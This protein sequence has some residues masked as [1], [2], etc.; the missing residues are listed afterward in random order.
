L[1]TPRFPRPP[2]VTDPLPRA[3]IHDSRANFGRP[4]VEA[5]KNARVVCADL[6]HRDLLWMAHGVAQATEGDGLAQRGERLLSVLLAG[7]K[8]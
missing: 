5:A 7:I 3:Q 8:A 1:I 4:L 6:D 2:K